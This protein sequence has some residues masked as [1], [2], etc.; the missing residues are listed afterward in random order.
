MSV[1]Y[2]ARNN[3]F[4]GQLD[5]ITNGV[6]NDGRALEANLAA[7]NAEAVVDLNGHAT[8]MVDFRNTFVA[9][10]VFE[11]TVGGNTY[12]TLAAYNIGT[13]AYVG[14][15]T[16]TGQTVQ[17]NVAGYKRVRVRLSAFTS[18]TVQVAMRASTAD[19]ATIV[20]RIPATSGITATGAA[21]AAVTLTIPAPG[22]GLFQYI[23]WIRIEHFATALLTAAAAPVIVTTTNIPGTP[24]FNFPAAAIAQG[25]VTEKVISNNMPVRAIAANTAVTVVCPA[26]TAV[27]WRATASYRVGA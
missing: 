27:I 1:L 19:F 25:V 5:Q 11:A 4:A 2:D 18:G 10:A 20:E 22:A 13:G 24:S 23:D 17:L 21:A 9:T 8:L 26:T 12:I 15:V 14:S 16:T 7:A 3:E 6:V